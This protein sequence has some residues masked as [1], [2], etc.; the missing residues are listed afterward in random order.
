MAR[1]EVLKAEVEKH[2][3]PHCCITCGN[4][5]GVESETITL[6]IGSHLLGCLGLLFGPI[7]WLIALVIWCRTRSE[8]LV[9]KTC[10]QC[11]LARIHLRNWLTFW[12]LCGGLPLVGLWLTD[13]G[14]EHPFVTCA[15]LAAWA[16]GFFQ[17]AWL[18]AQ[19][20]IRPLRI[21]DDRLL[22]EVPFDDYPSIY[23]RHLETATL[24]G[25]TDALGVVP[26]S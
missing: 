9:V 23:Q 24:Y 17:W 12:V 13:N 1:L 10:Y 25:S 22:L 4:D 8:D 18:R 26:E 21:K 2:G 20:R 11:H 16:W 6:K 5:D 3:F 7:G 19:F 15:G 14:S